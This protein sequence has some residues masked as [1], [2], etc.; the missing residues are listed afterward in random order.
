MPPTM[1]DRTWAPNGRVNAIVQVGDTVY[2][3]G[4][5]TAIVENGGAGPA[6]LSRE[7]LAA[8]DAS[9]GAPTAWA[10]SANG[11]VHALTASPDGSR[12]YAG[13][14]FTSIEGTPR[15]RLAAIASSGTGVVQAGWR[16]PTISA[17]VLTI[18]ASSSEVYAGGFFTTVGGRPRA[19]LA[20]FSAQNGSLDAGW[21]PSADDAVRALALSVDGTRAYAGGDFTTISGQPRDR[22]AALRTVTGG[23]V[24]AWRPDPGRRIFDLVPAGSTVYAAIGDEPEAVAAWDAATG[25]TSWEKRA[26]GD[27]HAVAVSGDVLYVGGHGTRFDGQTRGKLAG[28]DRA[29]GSLVT[30]WR[31]DLGGGAWGGVWALSTHADKRLVAA[32]DFNSVAGTRRDH[33]AQWTGAIGT[34]E[35]LPTLSTTTGIVDTTP[36]RVRGFSLVRSSFAV[37]PR[38]TPLASRRRRRPR[39]S[40]F[41]YR[42]SERA[43]VR[44]TI[45]R[46]RRRGSRR[47]SRRRSFKKVV[48]LRRPGRKGANRIAFSGRIRSRPLRAGRYRATL[49]AIDAAG[50]RSVPK[51][52]GFKIIARR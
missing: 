9:T 47:S 5:F 52:R 3:G 10:P 25:A 36:P 49:R 15:S 46:V 43:T 11:D 32:G 33:Y 4:T 50:N 16:T 13:G 21:K 22:A 34:L 23:V 24:A 28:F 2:V 40:A 7:N 12:I 35:T 29:T 14:S 48:V 18:A 31:P 17:G 44:I 6:S 27:V 42:L 45:E 1:P 38:R 8:F 41:R 39:G 51:R 19:K 37:G 20:A 30:D 26:S